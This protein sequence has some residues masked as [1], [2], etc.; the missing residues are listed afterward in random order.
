[1]H[2]FFK[3][4]NSVKLFSEVIIRSPDTMSKNK[5]RDTSKQMSFMQAC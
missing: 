3:M 2:L 1:M 5:H 4:E